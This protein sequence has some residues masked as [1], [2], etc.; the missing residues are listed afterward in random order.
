MIFAT[1]VI[2]HCFG[3]GRSI[4]GHRVV[5]TTGK[6]SI[7]FGP[8]GAMLISIV[9]APLLLFSSATRGIPT[10]LVQMNTA[11]IIGL[12]I[13]KVGEKEILTRTSVKRLTTVWIVSPFISLCLSF[14]LTVLGRKAGLP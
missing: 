14:L 13:S 9:T 2:A 1:L 6:E 12:G 11:A 7:E 8:V 5:Q 4:F 3:I 10:S